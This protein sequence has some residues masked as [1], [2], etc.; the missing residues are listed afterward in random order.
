VTVVEQ[1]HV[2]RRF[3]EDVLVFRVGPGGIHLLRRFCT[4]FCTLGEVL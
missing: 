4:W 3:I 1:N 2:V